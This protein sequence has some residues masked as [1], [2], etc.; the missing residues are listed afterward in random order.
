MRLAWSE[1]DHL[2]TM[3]DRVPDIRPVDPKLEV[4]PNRHQQANRLAASSGGGE[5]PGQGRF[6]QLPASLFGEGNGVAA[7]GR[8]DDR[9]FG[10]GLSLAA[11]HFQPA[12]IVGDPVAFRSAS[13]ASRNPS[14]PPSM[15]R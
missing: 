10:D 9:H 2:A 6:E 15:P 4:G 1:Y 7:G 11:V 12:K 3:R 5:I 8:I 13:T 14:N